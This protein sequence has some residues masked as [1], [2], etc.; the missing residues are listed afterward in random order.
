[1]CDG[2]D[3][4]LVGLQHSYCKYICEITNRLIKLFW[5]FSADYK[6]KFVNICAFS[7]IFF[8]DTDLKL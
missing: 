2:E 1:V 5:F 4:I 8:Q 3:I 7:N 6:N